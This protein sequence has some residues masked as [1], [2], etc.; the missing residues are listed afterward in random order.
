MIHIFQKKRFLVDYLPNFVDMHNHILPRID[1]GADNPQMAIDMLKV[2]GE[3]GISRFIATPHIMSN[4]YPND[5]NSIQA[6]LQELEKALLEE[7]LTEI[8]IDAAA[9]HMIDIDF[10]TN[11]R[12]NNVL[13]IKDS[14]LLIEMS[15][16]QPPLNFDEA[17][18]NIANKGFFPILAHPE[19]YM[20]LHH[21]MGKFEKY[22]DQGI[23][24]QLNLLSLSEYYGKDV[25][26]IAHKLLDAGLI[27]F[28]ATDLHNMGQL[29]QLKDLKL[30]DRVL[31]KLLPIISDTIEA[32]Y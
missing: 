26:K 15:Y 27:D 8:S 21:R 17:V 5:K 6:S 10:I 23:F 31:R 30:P 14:Y 1:D 4:L 28:V 18:I 20:F 24:L 32:F 19:R 16:L 25:Q 9:E 7:G 12:E 2:L 13:P 11:V 3:I 22:K 29:E